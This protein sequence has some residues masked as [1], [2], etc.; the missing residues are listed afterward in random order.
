MEK[1]SPKLEFYGGLLGAVSP[2][3]FFGI[4]LIYLV[5]KGMITMDAYLGPL[6][7]SIA[8]SI[9][10]AKDKK[11]VCES[12]LN[13]LTDKTLA[14]IIMAFIGAG[15]LGKL[16]TTSGAVNALVWVGYEIGATD[17]IFLVITFLICG[18]IA[19]ATGTS[20]GTCVTAVPILYPAGVLLGAH[21]VLLLGAIY[22]G[23]RFGD[24]IAPISDTTIASATTQDADI[25]A[26]V[27]SRLKYAFFAGVLTIIAYISANS[28]LSPEA[29]ST[30]LDADILNKY[31]ENLISILM[32][33]A[34]ITTVY[35]CLKGKSLLHALW[36]GILAGCIIGLCTGSLSFSDLY[37]VEAPKAVGGAL[38][39]GVLGM[40]TVVLFTI[41]LVGLLGPMK[42]A[43]VMEALAVWLSK[44]ATS[45]KKAEF[46][47]FALVSVM[48]PITAYNT[49]ALLF[50]GPLVKQIGEKFN[51]RAA[52]RA[53][54]MDMAGNGITG[55]FPHINTIL[56]LAAAMIAA[57]EVTEGVPIV[58]ITEIG[59]FAFYPIILTFT[60]LLAIATGWGRND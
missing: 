54:L 20:T 55:N 52:R 12:I 47:C 16:M 23:A 50:T 24:N 9:L 8:I 39:L 57:S 1:S 10:M 28:I 32:L 19:T 44:F 13:G 18:I 29:V 38:N 31:G 17:S 2:F 42:D 49:P 4:C 26:V 51:I 34:P 35:L 37:S 33:L 56:A 43:G 45:P 14:V 58:A 6:V 53:N 46:V 30:T 59:M 25:K 7:L 41:F 11:A 5:C 48:Y 40:G 21:P 15:V 22:S 27:R 3:I 60:A 36:Y